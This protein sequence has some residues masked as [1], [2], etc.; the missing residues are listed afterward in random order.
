MVLRWQYVINDVKTKLKDLFENATRGILQSW[1]LNEALQNRGT[2]W[3]TARQI[4]VENGKAELLQESI[5]GLE[6]LGVIIDDDN[7]LIVSDII[8]DEKIKAQRIK[9]LEAEQEAEAIRRKGRGRVDE[10]IAFKKKAIGFG[11]KEP[12]PTVTM[13]DSEIVAYL[14]NRSSLEAVQNSKANL[15]LVA[16]A[17]NQVATMF[18][19]GG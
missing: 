16:Q 4:Y 11:D 12:D 10:L 7:P 19:A 3:Q 14:L 5:R 2:L 15:T 17:M 1:T 9:V 13:S 6:D 18:N 8:L